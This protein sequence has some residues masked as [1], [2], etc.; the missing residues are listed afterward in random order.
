M[1][2]D[3]SWQPRSE[4][5]WALQDPEAAHEA[6]PRGGCTA[7]APGG[8]E[9]T[10]ERSPTGAAGQ[11]TLW[12]YTKPWSER[13]QEEEGAGA[14]VE[15]PSRWVCVGVL[16]LGFGPKAPSERQPPFSCPDDMVEDANDEPA[17]TQEPWECCPIC[18]STARLP[19]LS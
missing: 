9:A 18:R 3:L 8:K 17:P 5:L 12:S 13:D 10:A 4:Q 11:G 14:R 15:H 6:F 1:V 2:K 7:E 19:N 16:A